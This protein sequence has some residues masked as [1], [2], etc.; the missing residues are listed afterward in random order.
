MASKQKTA[1]AGSS[2]R[3]SKIVLWRD[4]FESSAQPLELQSASIA[5]RFG[6]APERARLV[7]QLAFGEMRL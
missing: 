6:L 2:E 3:L 1:G 5:R 4:N 7:A